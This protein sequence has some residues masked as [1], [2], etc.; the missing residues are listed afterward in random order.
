MNTAFLLLLGVTLNT[1]VQEN[2]MNLDSLCSR[3]YELAKVQFPD[4]KL[5][6]QDIGISV[7]DAKLG[8]SGNFQGDEQKYPA[9]VVK[10]FWLAF[11]AHQVDLKKIKMTPEIERAATDMIVDSNNDA[12]GAIVNLTTGALP[13][14]ELTGKALSEWLT[15]RQA[16]NTWFASMGYTGVN[17]CQ[18]TYNEGPYGREKQG[19]GP[20]GELRNRLTPNACVRVMKDIMADK[21][22]SKE[23]CSWM[24]KLLKRNNPV[25]FPKSEDSQAVNFIGSVIPKGYELYSKAGWTSTTRHDLAA[26]NLPGQ[27]PLI[28][29]IMTMKPNNEKLLQFIAKTIVSELR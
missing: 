16:C 28:I 13:G 24:K 20:N 6:I 17:A 22:V 14:P 29:C 27:P 26:I 1:N 15:K 25:D 8:Q 23:G 10:I 2:P 4:E 19:V 11:L 9:S 3:T 18:R 12:T 7:Y 21:I 5:A